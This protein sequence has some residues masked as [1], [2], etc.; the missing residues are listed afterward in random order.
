MYNCYG[1]VDLC[2]PKYFI[3]DGKSTLASS[4]RLWFVEFRISR[5]VCLFHSVVYLFLFLMLLLS[6]GVD[7]LLLVG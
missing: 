4:L 5:W 6:L 2:L 1:R 7:R 3:K